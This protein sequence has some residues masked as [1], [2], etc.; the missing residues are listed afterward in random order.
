MKTV[1]LDV[2][3]VNT[4]VCVLDEDGAVLQETRIATSRKTL[5]KALGK[6][7]RMRILLESSTESEWVA[8][9]LE[10]LG[11]EVIV[12]D[13]GYAPMY[14][15]RVRRVKTDR[16]DARALAE[17][18]RTGTYRPAHR[19]SEEHRRVRA[20]LTVREALVRTRT[21]YIS[22]VGA[23]L[24]GEGLRVR[25][26]D[27]AAFVERARE[28]EMPAHLETMLTPLLEI[29]DDVSERLKDMDHELEVTAREDAVVRRLCTVPGVGP[30]T[31]M[32]FKAVI[33]RVDRFGRAHELES[34]L[35]LVPGERSSGEK[36][37]RG[38]LTKRGNTRARWLLVEA[39][40]TMFRGKAPGTQ[41]LS[42]WGQ[43]IAARRGKRIAVVALARR[44]AGILFALW[45]DQTDFDPR[46][47][48]TATTKVAL[49]A[50]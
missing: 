22:I 9:H 5:A 8:R 32:T 49:R 44:M 33:D 30:V 43:R 10:G 16:R 34:Y 40:W 17:A 45:R 47:I 42:A 20:G 48:R 2:H 41:A 7:E 3:K 26:G 14:P 35:G 12:A 37:Q 24:R 39:A 28:V 46:K 50:A 23:L 21:R 11:H 36:R 4:Q 29:M 38:H 31:A 18:C 25:S 15:H 1:G 6:S 13:P 27:A 19:T